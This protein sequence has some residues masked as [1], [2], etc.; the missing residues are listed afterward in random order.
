MKLSRFLNKYFLITF[1]I[2]SSQNILSQESYIEDVIV[3]AEKRS[4][5]IQDISQSIT[6]LK[7]SDL[8]SKNITSFVDLSG[9]VPGVTVAKNEGY[10]TVISIRG[11][12][13]ETNQNAIAAPSVAFHMDGIFIASPF[14]LQTDFIDVERIE[15]LR[16][17]QGTLFG[18][19]STGGAINVISTKPSTEGYGGKADFTIGNYALR[20]FRTS[21]NIPLNKKLATRFSASITERDGFTK[22]LVT[23]QDL[24]DAS[25]ISLRSDWLFDIDNRSSLRVFGQYFEVD[26][27]GSAIKGVDDISPNPRELYQD[28]LSNHDLTSTVIGVIYEKDLGFANLKAM[29]SSQDDDISVNRDNDRHNFGDL[30]KVI[31]GLGSDATY[32]RAEY[33]SESS[34]VETKTFEINLVSNEPLFGGLDW[35]L[36]AFYM[37]H[38]IENSIRGYRDNN[39]DGSI[40]YECSN[41]NA[42]VGACYDHDY[43]I[44]GRF[45]VFDAEWDFVTDAFPSR[46][47]Y[48]IY[49]QTT[50]SF[51]EDLRL[52]S[53][54]RYSEDTFSTSVSNFYNVDVFEADGDVDKLTGKVVGE[55]DL[56]DV[57]MAYVSF[58]QGFKPG[59]SNLTYGY[60]EAEDVA[61]ARPVAPA[62]VF[63]TYESENIESLEIGLKTALF[64][65]KARA[66]I[67]LFS[68]DYEN[69]QFQ[70]TDPDPYRGG[71]ANI[72]ESDMTGLE[73]EFRALLSDSLSMDVN[74]AFLNSEVSSNYDVLDNVDAY[75][76]F[77]GQEDLRYSLKENVKGN[78]LAKSPDFSANINL[79]YETE[80]SSGNEFKGA[81]QFLR[82]GEFEQRVSN[83]PAV[84]SIP[85]YDIYNLTASVSFIDSGYAF[86][87]MLLNVA[88]KGGINSSMTDV[89]GVA[90]TGLEYISPRQFMVRLSKTF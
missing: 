31:P 40:L 64:N 84:D 19:N 85:A 13:N 38:D 25:N 53:G 10:K 77:F 55:F 32:Q 69:L 5:S 48:S 45:A 83:N 59:G 88:D 89:F 20:K 9:I 86:D 18:Q 81:F 4:E 56:S 35:T 70:A 57:A 82:R 29:A 21:N 26:R 49:A 46:K 34:I 14:S 27:N 16:G 72:P 2:I 62:M 79:V 17:P 76:Y 41:S 78:E 47:S 1:A 12:G 3:T 23:G 24:D 67:A 87:L 73:V 37:E 80:L 52:V 60:T 30:V 42:L 39:N 61:A 15:V 54:L 50:Y 58:S 71:V 11:V 68:Y 7:G 6:A 44:P 36:G 28:S 74:L 43:G 8:D 33:N 65:G 66:N 51:T 90:A 22:N 63:Q 75:Q